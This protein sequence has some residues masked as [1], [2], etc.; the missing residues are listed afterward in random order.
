[1]VADKDK[2]ELDFE[3]LLS[4]ELKVKLVFMVIGIAVTTG[5]PMFLSSQHA[6]QQVLEVQQSWEKFERDRLDRE[7]ARIVT[8][9]ADASSANEPAPPSCW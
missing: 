8:D 9:N 6:K 3:P 7:R 1:M 4:P 5:L 2:R